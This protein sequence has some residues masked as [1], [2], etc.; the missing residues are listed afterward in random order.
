MVGV[1]VCLKRSLSLFRGGGGMCCLHSHFDS[2]FSLIL[3]LFSV[4]NLF[5]DDRMGYFYNPGI[6]H[7]LFRPLLGSNFC[8]VVWPNL[9]FS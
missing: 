6:L 2:N 5:S 9:L 7:R 4:N 1:P 3:I 8:Y